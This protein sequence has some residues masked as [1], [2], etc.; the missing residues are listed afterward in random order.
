MYQ[1]QWSRMG[2]AYSEAN[3]NVT[4]VYFVLGIEV[5]VSFYHG[6]GHIGN[7]Q[8]LEPGDNPFSFQMTPMVF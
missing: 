7:K 8:Q 6:Y 1:D 5:E 4:N 3:S 2:F